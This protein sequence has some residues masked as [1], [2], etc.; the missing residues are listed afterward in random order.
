MSAPGE[1]RAPSLLEALLLPPQLPA[2]AKIPTKALC[3]WTCRCCSERWAQILPTVS[4]GRIHSTFCA[5]ALVIP[6]S[7]PSD[8]TT[9]DILLSSFKCQTPPSSHGTVPGYHVPASIFYLRSHRSA[10]M[11]DRTLA[12]TCNPT[13]T[14][15][16]GLRE[17]LELKRLCEYN[18][19]LNRF[20]WEMGVLFTI[21]EV[22]HT[23]ARTALWPR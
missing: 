10:M 2:T 20:R 8:D 21:Q 16:K 12:I 22:Q 6:V 7:Q 17:P 1:G 5:S 19:S 14:A 4:Q 9:H 18:V 23:E 11:D 13:L 3:A 15:G